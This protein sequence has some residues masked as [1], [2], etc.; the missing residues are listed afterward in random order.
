MLSNT[1]TENRRTCQISG[2]KI[3]KTKRQIGKIDKEIRV[4]I[5]YQIMGQ[6]SRLA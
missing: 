4:V 3:G 5:A 1:R 2:L 6:N